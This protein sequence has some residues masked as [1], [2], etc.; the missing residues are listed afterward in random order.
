MGRILYARG[1]HYV[2]RTVNFPLKIYLWFV[3]RLSF[4]QPIYY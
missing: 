4:S 3:M 1:V 2:T